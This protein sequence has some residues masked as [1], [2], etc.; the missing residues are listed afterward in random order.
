[1]IRASRRPVSPSVR[2]TRR[3]PAATAGSVP[4]G[5][6]PAGHV[7]A[8]HVPAGHVPAGH[9]PAG[10]VPSGPGCLLGS[11]SAS[12]RQLRSLAGAGRAALPGTAARRAAA[13]VPLRAAEALGFRGAALPGT[14]SGLLGAAPPPAR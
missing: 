13:S 11:D 4:A 12:P 2:N 7:P 10:H 14:A 9:A 8:G 1:M 5:H 3:A 6:V